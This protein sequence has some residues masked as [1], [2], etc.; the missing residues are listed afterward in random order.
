MGNATG[1]SN[2]ETCYYYKISI[3]RD[4]YKKFVYYQKSTKMSNKAE[5]CNARYCFHYRIRV[6]MNIC[7]VQETNDVG[8]FYYHRIGIKEDKYNAFEYYKKSTN[9]GFAMGMY[10]I[11]VCYYYGMKVLKDEYKAFEYYKKLAVMGF[12]NRM[13]YVGKFY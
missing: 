8:N 3:E 4:F 7:D 5:T 9:I 10:N 11:E 1:I 6:E 13:Y 12:A 2:V